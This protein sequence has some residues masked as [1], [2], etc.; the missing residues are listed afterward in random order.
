MKRGWLNRVREAY[1]QPKPFEQS[2]DFYRRLGVRHF[3]KF[4]PRGD[5]RIRLTGQKSLNGKSGLKKLEFQTRVGEAIHLVAGTVMVA[6]TVDEL[7]DGEYKTAAIGTGVNLLI[8]VYPIMTHRYIRSR[9]YP[10][11]ERIEERSEYV[12]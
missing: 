5:Y 3:K 4:T 7:A 1:F 8:N 2:G 11:L 12:K 6:L 10:L 9:I